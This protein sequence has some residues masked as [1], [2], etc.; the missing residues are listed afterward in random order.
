VADEVIAGR[1]RL[2]E[3]LGAGGMSEVWSA[4]DL[5]LGRRVA[6]KLLAPNADRARFE[7]E[8]R[9][10]AA[11]AHLNICALYGYGETEGR[12][13]MVLEYLPGGSLEDRLTRGQPLP[14]DETWRIAGELAAG[15]AHAHQRGLVHRD[16]KPSNVLFDAEGRAKIADFGI[17]RL[18]E[19]SG[20]TQLGTVLGTATIISPEQAAGLP[21]T[22]ASDVY[23]FG[24]I[25]YRLLTGR[26]P[27]EADDA[28][29]LATMHR[30]VPPP[31][32]A[33]F[34]PAAPAA[35][36]SIA[37]AA[38]AKSPAD[39]PRD[40]AALVAELAGAAPPA[41]GDTAATQIVRPEPGPPRSRTAIVVAAA[42]LLAAAGVA[43][44]IAVTFR[45]GTTSP[46]PSTSLPTTAPTTTP[47]VLPTGEQT[48]E[49][50]ATEATTT[51]PVTTAE[52]PATTTAIET[53][54]P[55]PT[56]APVTTAAQPP[57]P[58]PPPSTTA[59]PV[60][61]D[62]TATDTT[63]PGTTVSAPPVQ[64]G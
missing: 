48:T 57:P 25:L 61:T 8:A 36:E 44:A 49:A 32:L 35:L 6:V 10:A 17:A 3:R 22:P 26:L 40:G 59:P 53:T 23:A 20:L 19:P 62:T 29:A 54:A 5:D 2:E 64:P 41:R 31:P 63:A 52:P 34:R 28:L 55:T 47:R 14:D 12:P 58:P 45:G 9:S 46:L 39:R 24:V 38:L 13:F 51:E 33:G 50:A 42:A 60:T 4:L 56:T 30:D 43:L 11:L 16:L 18:G 27:F 15:L 21:A 1:Y 7:R 37:M